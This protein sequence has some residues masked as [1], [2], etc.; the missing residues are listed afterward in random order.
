MSPARYALALACAIALW[1]RAGIPF[2]SV[3][4]PGFVNFQET[5]AWFHV[6]IIEHLVHHFP[7]RLFIDPYGSVLDGQRVDTGPF[8]DWLAAA[9]AIPF[10]NHLHAILAWYPAILGVGI[11]VAVY[12]LTRQLSSAPSAALAALITAT[13]PGYFLAISSLGF[14]DH[15]VMESLLS[16]LVIFFLIPI[17]IA[18]G[19][20]F[21]PFF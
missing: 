4:Q 8:Y 10:P 7:H 20:F 14:T 15:H 11:V 16:T 9:L 19:F 6:R 2:Y 12:F 18:N 1:I 5:D 13:L 3:F 21:V 17:G